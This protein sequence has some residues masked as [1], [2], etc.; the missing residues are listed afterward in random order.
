[1]HLCDD[2]PPRQVLTLKLDTK[3]SLN[4]KPLEAVAI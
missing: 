1:M 2:V 3:Y 4:L